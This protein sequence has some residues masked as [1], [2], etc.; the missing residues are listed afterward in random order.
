MSVT[1]S[2]RRFDLDWLRVFAILTVFIFHSCRFFVHE[3]WHVHNLTAYAGAD[4][5]I[6]FLSSWMMPVIMVISGASAFYSLG[7]GGALRFIK[8]KVLRLLIPLLLGIFTSSII[9]VYLERLTHGQ[10]KG[11]IIDFLPHYFEGM[12][13]FGGN[14]AWMGLHLWYLEVLFVFSLLFLPLLSWW[15]G[16]GKNVLNWLGNIFALPGMIYVMVLP[17]ILLLIDQSSIL[18]DNAFGGW[19]LSEYMVLFV[20]GFIIIASPRLQERI[21]QMRWLSLPLALASCAGLQYFSYVRYDENLSGLFFGLASWF[22]ILAILGFGFSKLNFTNPFLKYAN[23]AV[24]PFY[25]LHQTVLLLIGWQVTQWAI[26]DLAK[27]FIIAITSF[28]AIIGTYEVIRRVNVFRFLFGMKW[29]SRQAVTAN[30][31][32]TVPEELALRRNG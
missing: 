2:T 4:M 23:E 29:L 1:A 6:T 30:K 15:K 22:P 16:S 24:L 10:F 21:R 25:I 32:T 20:Y 9:M 3:D 19:S 8:D 5:W 17:I 31:Q 11:S 13:A 18:T 14:F 28:A 7:K 26:P 12:Y 27:Y